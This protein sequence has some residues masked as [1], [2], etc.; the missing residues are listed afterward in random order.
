VN[1]RRLNVLQIIGAKISTTAAR[2]I[3]AQATSGLPVDRDRDAIS[4][5]RRDRG[6]RQIVHAAPSAGRTAAKTGLLAVVVATNGA[7]ST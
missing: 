3:V 6:D 2:G 1:R 7:V 5:A 4:V